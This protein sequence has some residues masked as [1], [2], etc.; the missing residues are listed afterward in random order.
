MQNSVVIDCFQ[1]NPEIHR[2]G[3]AIVAID[4]IRATTTAITAVASGR[5]CFPVPSLEA[6]KLIRKELTNPLLAGEVG[7]YLLEGFE[8]NNSPA[9]IAMRT[10][11]ERPLV[12][13]SSSGTKLIHAAR[14]SDFTYLACFRNHSTISQHLI[15]HH[16]KVALIGAGTR[17]EFREEDQICCAWI[18]RQLIAAGYE[19]E[20]ARTTQI[21]DVWGAAP[22]D[23]CLCSTS[24]EYLRRSGQTR[25]LDF[26]L[27]HINDL[28]FVYMMKDNQVVSLTDRGRGEAQLSMTDLTHEYQY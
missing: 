19:A 12:L 3:Y 18:A 23:A 1:E 22:E 4:V 6:A 9:E 11:I 25:D 14:E 28:P 24:A 16:P 7:G 17:G 13:L 8:A 2:K 15:D 27:S 26:T 5:R 20:N 10:D 21:V